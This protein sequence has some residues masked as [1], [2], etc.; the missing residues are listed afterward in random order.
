MVKS[1]RK[2]RQY[3]KKFHKAQLV[4]EAIRSLWEIEEKYDSLFPGK[5]K[6]ERSKF[7]AVI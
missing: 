1:D 7:S 5:I 4:Y 6:K 2:K 3:V